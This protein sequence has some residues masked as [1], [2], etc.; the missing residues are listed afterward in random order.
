MIENTCYNAYTEVYEILNH[1]PIT[2][3]EKIPFELLNLF[4]QKRNKEYKYSVDTKK[5]I[6]EQNM[7][8][9]TKAILS[10]LYKEYWAEPSIK[11]KILQ[12]EE[13]ERIEYQNALR[14]K[15]NPENVFQTNSHSKETIQDK[16]NKTLSNTDTIEIYKDNIWRKFI[17]KIKNIFKL[18]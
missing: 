6:N 7:L 16:S 1:M 13:K 14:E 9:K 8:I 12:R 15:Y 11:E 2:Y 18:K 10:T 3:V 17:N 5:K 4:E